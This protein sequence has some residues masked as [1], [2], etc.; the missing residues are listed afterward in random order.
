MK[1][2]D[3]FAGLGGFHLSL[4]RLGHECVFASE[5]DAGLASLYEKN[6]GITPDGDITKV[7][8][9]NIPHH[10]ILCGGFPCQPFSKAGEQSGLECTTSGN[11]FSVIDRIIRHHKPQYVLLENVANLERHDAGRTWRRRIRPRLKGA[12]YTVDA[13]LLSPHEFGIPQV[14]PRFFIVASRRGLDDFRWPEPPKTVPELSVR[15]VLDSNPSDATALSEQMIQCLEVWQEFLER[16][17]SDAKLSGF[18]KWSMEWGATYPYENGDTPKSIGPR[19]LAKYLGSHGAVIPAGGWEK[20]ST[21]LPSYA[22]EFVF[23]KWKQDFIRDNRQFYEQNKHWIDPWKS[24]IL[25][26]PQ[27]LQKFEW[28]CKGEERNLWNTVIQFRASGVRCK[29][30]T[31]APS[32]VAMTTTQVPIIGWERRYMTPRECSR[33]QSMG[34]LQHLP[35]TPTRAYKALGNSVNVDV[36][37]A[38]AQALLQS[39]GPG[40]PP[41]V[42]NGRKTRKKRIVAL[43]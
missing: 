6:F 36:V 38:V 30:P 3:L 42:T 12:G 41:G 32:L 2:I 33:L 23:P 16:A 8:I 1:F 18:P 35:A 31:T 14:R 15:S 28:N 26:F 40:G 5:I 27:S 13:R 9:E 37:E 10:D 43:A 19:R 39:S 11:L 22:R 21:V 29:R 25:A 34:D 17:P 4:T 7:D 20:Q 24:S